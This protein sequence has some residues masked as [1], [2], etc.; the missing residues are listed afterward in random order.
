MRR[1]FR[2]QIL[3]LYFIPRKCFSQAQAEASVSSIGRVAFHPSSRFANVVSAQIFSISPARRPTI[4]CG[5]STPVTFFER[6]DQ[7]D[8][9]TPLTGAHVEKLVIRPALAA[10][11]PVDRHHMRAGQVDHVDI[12]PD[13]R[14]VRRIVI[15]P[16]N[17]QARPNP[18]RRLRNKRNEV[19]RNPF[20]APR[21]T[22]TDAPRSG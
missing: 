8:H 16:E 14:T 17:T 11:H 22:P 15:V 1:F 2:F 12:V 3:S 13:C 20:Q 9:R 6:F 19:A 4:L 10:D 5:T 18:G 7:F 21:S